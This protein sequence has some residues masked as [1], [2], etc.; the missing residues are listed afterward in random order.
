M[1]I[2]MVVYMI[3]VICVIIDIYSDNYDI[4]NLHI[5]VHILASYWQIQ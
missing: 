2:Y 1:E 4:P 3:I 5:V